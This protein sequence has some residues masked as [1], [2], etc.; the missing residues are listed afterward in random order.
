M[1]NNAENFLFS[2]KGQQIVGNILREL[3]LKESVLREAGEIIWF[4]AKV[5]EK[6]K[7]R[8]PLIRK[9]LNSSIQSIETSSPLR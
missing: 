2:E 7:L 5:V 1:K 8:S 6:L 9:L 4:L 3:I